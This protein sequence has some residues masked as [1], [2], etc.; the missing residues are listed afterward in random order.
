L[1]GPQEGVHKEEEVRRVLGLGMLRVKAQ[2]RDLYR[3]KWT[4]ISYTTTALHV[5]ALTTFLEPHIYAILQLTSTNRSTNTFRTLRHK[6]TDY[7]V[8][9]RDG[10][11]SNDIHQ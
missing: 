7:L 8:P 4:R 11:N 6:A 2:Q 5:P 10:I 3:V 9:P 1:E